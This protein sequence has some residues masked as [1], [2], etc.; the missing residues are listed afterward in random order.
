MPLKSMWFSYTLPFLK[1]VNFILG[2][3]TKLGIS[4]IVLILTSNQH[5]RPLLKNHKLQVD[6]YLYGGDTT[7]IYSRW[8]YYGDQG[9]PIGYSLQFGGPSGNYV[10]D[11]P[12]IYMIHEE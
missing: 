6:P 8:T 12:G 5:L 11:M 1:N 7:Y 4:L 2:M 9:G 3:K 10:G